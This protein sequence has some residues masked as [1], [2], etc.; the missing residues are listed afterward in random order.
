MQACDLNDIDGVVKYARDT[1][2]TWGGIQ[3]VIDWLKGKL[4][5]DGVCQY[6]D[7]LIAK[8]DWAVEQIVAIDVPGI[9]NLIVEPFLDEI[10]AKV[11]KAQ[12]RSMIAKV[13]P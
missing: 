8:A 9:P 6:K 12:V 4:S 13:C 10:L 3:N 2:G 11:A 7:V 1:E 5:L